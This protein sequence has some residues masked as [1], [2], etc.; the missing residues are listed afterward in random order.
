MQRRPEL[1][2]RPLAVCGSQEECHGIVLTVNYIAK[3]FG[4]KTGMAIWQAKKRCSDLVI[5]PP[6]MDEYIRISKMAREIYEDYT[7]RVETFGP[8][9]VSLKDL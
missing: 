9:R 4:V 7:D 5:V 2:D 8:D 1:R 3:P 6:D